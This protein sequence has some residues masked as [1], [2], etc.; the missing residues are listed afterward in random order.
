MGKGMDMV[1]LFGQT[2][3]LK[4]INTKDNTK[5]EKEVELG[6]TL[7]KVGIDT[8]DSMKMGNQME[9]DWVLW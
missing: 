5:M 1:L 9:R 3:I 4:A 6:F 2:A 7:N 8:K